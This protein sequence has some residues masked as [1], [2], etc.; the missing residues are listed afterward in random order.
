MEYIHSKGL[1]FHDVKPS[2]MAIGLTNPNQI[3]FFDFAF[4]EFYVNAMGESKE[5]EDAPD[6]NGTPEYMGRGPL[7]RYTH[8]RKDDFISL[9]LVLLELNGVELPWMNL[10]S[11]DDDI[12][13]TMDIVLETWDDYGIDEICNAS[14]KPDVF[15]E[16]F[17]YLD[18]LES[19][20]QPDYEILVELFE[21]Q[22]TPEEL[23]SDSLGISLKEKIDLFEEFDLDDDDND[24]TVT[25]LAINYEFKWKIPEKYIHGVVIDD[26]FIVGEQLGDGH[27]GFV[28]SGKYISK[29]YSNQ[30]FYQSILIAAIDMKTGNEVAIKFAPEDTFEFLE[31]E[32]VNYLYLG[33]DGNLLNLYVDFLFSQF[34]SF[35]NRI[36][37]N[38]A[39]RILYILVNLV[40]T[41]YW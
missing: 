40:D 21:K 5:R 6:I 25:S 37:Y 29:Q 18:T 16:Y 26:R 35:Q 24:N 13:R 11:E 41:K 34:I 23:E 12:Y 8:V 9:G 36:S 20:E 22:L 28:R 15:I 1:I 2:N 7:N 14:D 32:F 10:T 27:T 39:Y 30:I 3:I 31:K 19:Y 38:M 17:N 4:S 33:G